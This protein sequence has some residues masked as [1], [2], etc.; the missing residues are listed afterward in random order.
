MTYTVSSGALNSTPTNQPMLKFAIFLF[1]AR[2]F[3][4]RV[5]GKPAEISQ[6]LT[7]SNCGGNAGLLLAHTPQQGPSPRSVA[8]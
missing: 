2:V 7:Y 6:N 3:G 4:G 1:I 8:R 5:G